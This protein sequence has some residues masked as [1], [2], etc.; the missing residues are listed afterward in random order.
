MFKLQNLII[1]LALSLAFSACQNEKAEDTAYQLGVV[2]GFCEL[3]NAG[4]KNIALSGTM[5]SA[6]MDDFLPKAQQVADDHGVEIFRETDLIRTDLFPEDIAEGLEVLLFYQG[7]KLDR[8]L[9]LKAD[10]KALQAKGEYQGAER[11][12][13]ARRFGRLL[14]YSPQG[15]NKLLSQN[16]DYRTLADFGIKAT[17]VFLYYKDLAAATRFYQDILGLELIADY[18]MATI[19][20]LAEE[21]YL[22]L[23]NAAEGMHSA[24]EP[25]TVALALLSDQLDEWWTYLN[26]QKVP[27][28]Y[29]Y[30]PKDGGA[31][32]GFVMID[33]EGYLL[34]FE[35]F[36]QHPENEGFVPVLAKAKT[37]PAT[38]TSMVP[39]GLGFKASITWLYYKDVLEMEAFY[40]NVLGLE[41]VADQGWTKIYQASSTGFIGLVDEARGMHDFTE[42][43]AVTVSFFLESLE[44]WFD[45]NK[46][47]KPF[48]LRNDSLEIGPENRYRAFIGYDPGG[49]FM[50]F[51]DFGEHP[52]NQKLLNYLK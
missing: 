16:T 25:K 49:Y 8:Y 46:I 33:P 45:Y 43:K 32:D 22:I 20:R 37:I 28:K 10:Q 17:N 52:D 30:K 44:G 26:A 23:V 15:V 12:A 35:R 50:E 48:A 18:E 51:N 29:S 11:E 5:T 40:E 21:S 38:S 41:L 13:I 42:E 36:K 6:E 47:G 1:V 34:E 2:G 39:E 9:Q 27:V 4:V 7:N 3:V 31:H 14:S 24:D 19:F